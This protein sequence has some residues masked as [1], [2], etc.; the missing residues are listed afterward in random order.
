METVPTGAKLSIFFPPGKG[1]MSQKELFYISVF[2][3]PNPGVP[4]PRA[5][6]RCRFIVC[7]ELGH[8]AGVERWAKLKPFPLSNTHPA[9]CGK[10]S[11]TKSVLCTKKIG[12]CF[13]KHL[14]YLPLHESKKLIVASKYHSFSPYSP[15]AC[16]TVYLYPDFNSRQS[17]DG[18]W[19]KLQKS[20]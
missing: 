3:S 2:L 16:R 11:S 4:N 18:I 5:M 14:P 7:W 17:V 9:V 6:N 13:P 20:Q 8:T 19:N 15:Y 1:C 12:D 10:L